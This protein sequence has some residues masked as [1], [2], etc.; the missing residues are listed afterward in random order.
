M[1]KFLSIILALM[2]L[3]AFAGCAIKLPDV[4]VNYN[5]SSGESGVNKVE[6]K[7]NNPFVKQEIIEDFSVYVPYDHDIG[8]YESSSFVSFN[9]DGEHITVNFKYFEGV[10]YKDMEDTVKNDV[11]G[12][13][14]INGI[15]YTL[16]ET[17][18]DTGAVIHGYIT[19]CNNRLYF[20]N[21]QSEGGMDSELLRNLFM[22]YVTIAE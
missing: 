16:L 19:E 14:T 5:S 6:T 10:T 1:K 9:A 21:Y 18:L 7:D 4:K 15:K 3:A 8:G 2:I 11:V 22:S 20:I 13:T 17:T 12:E